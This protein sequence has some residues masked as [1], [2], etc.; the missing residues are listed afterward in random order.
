MFADLQAAIGDVEDLSP[1][2]RLL[3]AVMEMRATAHASFKRVNDDLVGV[4][5]LPGRAVLQK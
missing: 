2:G 4:G 5:D 3:L 1:D